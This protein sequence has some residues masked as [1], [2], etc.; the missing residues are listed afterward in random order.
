MPAVAARW[1]AEPGFRRGGACSIAL[2]P[3]GLDRLCRVRRLHAAT[4]YLRGDVVDDAADRRAEALIVEVLV[5]ARLRESAGDLFH[6]GVVEPGVGALHHRDDEI[7]G[8][9]PR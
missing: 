2:F 1:R 9:E 7:T 5:V 6:E 4:G 3:G 8:R